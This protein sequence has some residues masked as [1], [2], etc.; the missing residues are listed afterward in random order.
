MTPVCERRS[1]SASTRCAQ[2]RD[3]FARH[4]LIAVHGRFLIAFAREPL[5]KSFTPRCKLD[6]VLRAVLRRGKFN[7]RPARLHRTKRVDSDLSRFPSKEVFRYLRRARPTRSP[8][9]PGKPDL[10]GFREA[11]QFRHLFWGHTAVIQPV[12]EYHYIRRKTVAT[13]VR[14]LPR[15]FRRV[16]VQSA[17]NRH[18][19]FGATWVVTAVRALLSWDYVEA[20]GKGA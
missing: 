18:S 16:L 5:M 11:H 19:E 14:T 7:R 15:P 2:L 9:G 3:P 12:W 20:A 8:P 17:P 4:Q 6:P 13:H 10:T 1:D